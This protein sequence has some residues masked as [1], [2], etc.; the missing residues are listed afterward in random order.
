VF[1]PGD[2]VH[3][4]RVDLGL[5]VE[6]AG[7]GAAA[8]YTCEDLG[9]RVAAVLDVEQARQGPKNA[10]PAWKNSWAGTCSANAAGWLKATGT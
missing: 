8:T 2:V 4:S 1:R 3:L 5:E 6:D 7:E 10:S 9:V